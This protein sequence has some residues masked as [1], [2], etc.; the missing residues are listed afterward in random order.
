MIDEEK[1]MLFAGCDPGVYS[2]TVAIID[3]CCNLI[4]WLQIYESEADYPRTAKAN[5]KKGQRFFDPIPEK[6]ADDH[7][8]FMI[9]IFSKYDLQGIATEKMEWSASHSDTQGWVHHNRGIMHAYCISQECPF[10]MINPQQ[11]KKTV[12]GKGNASKDEVVYSIYKRYEDRFPSYKFL[13]DNNHIA[14]SI[15]A[16]IHLVRQ[17]LGYLEE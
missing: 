8:K 4:E 14:D 6:I 2:T 1:P 5:R 11:I 7:Y 9:G 15:G 10:H 13:S 17:Q 12:T 16:A 3:S